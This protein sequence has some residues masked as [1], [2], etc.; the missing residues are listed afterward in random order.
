M[1]QPTKLTRSGFLEVHS[2]DGFVEY[3]DALEADMLTDFT[4]VS[5]SSK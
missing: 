3:S 5:D 4:A 2:D 1:R